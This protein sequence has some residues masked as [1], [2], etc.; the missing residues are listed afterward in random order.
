MALKIMTYARRSLWALISISI[1]LSIIQLLHIQ[2]FLAV[3]T[4][5]EAL[6]MKMTSSL[7]GKEA[8]VRFITGNETVLDTEVMTLDNVAVG[9][10]LQIL[11]NPVIP[12]QARID[13]FFDIWF[14]IL[15]YVM[16]FITSFLLL[17]LIH[18]ISSWRERRLKKLRST[19]HRILTQ[20][21]KVEAVLK[22]EKDGRCPFRIVSTWRD[23]KSKK[24]YEFR[25]QYIWNNPT[26]Y[27][28]DQTIQVVFDVKNKRKYMMDLSFLP[29]NILD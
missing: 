11:Y 25:S 12:A 27:I 7:P 23:P 19:G 26:D 22:A 4:K 14:D 20:F 5:T 1:L 3:S 24:T 8:T 13:S 18:Y 21:K 6:V 28:M 29:E 10:R 16:I 17:F 15:I 9:E 2:H